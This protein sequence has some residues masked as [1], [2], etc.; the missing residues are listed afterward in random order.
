M[1][2]VKSSSMP[3]SPRSGCCRLYL[4]AT[5]LGLPPPSTTSSTTTT[6]TSASKGYHLHVVLAGFY[7]SHS[8]HAITTLSL[9]GDVRVYLVGYIFC[10]IDCHICQYI[11]GRI[12]IIYCKLPYVSRG[13]LPLKTLTLYIPA[14]RHNAIQPIIIR[15]LFFL[16]DGL[17][18]S[19]PNAISATAFLFELN[20]LNMY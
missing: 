4:A 3:P 11:F 20:E 15:N 7:S 19:T 13:A 14:E 10:I 16:Q 2:V 12:D 6:S 9:R 5:Q 1:L 18:R 8:I 17:R